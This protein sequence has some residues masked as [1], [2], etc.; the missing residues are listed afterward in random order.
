MTHAGVIRPYVVVLA[1][2]AVA[3]LVACNNPGDQQGPVTQQNQAAP[4]APAL[5]LIDA[6]APDLDT[7]YIKYVCTTIDSIGFA[8]KN[9]KPAWNHQRRP[10]T[11][12]HPVTI[13]WKVDS[14]VTID[15]IM[16]KPGPD[17]FPID[18]DPV[19]K[20]GSPGTLYKGTVQSTAGA[21]GNPPPGNP[22][23]R[24]YPYQL[25]LTCG[26]GPSPRH[27]VVDPEMII[28]KP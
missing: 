24:S 1:L 26:T 21:P 19:L 5:V 8:D 7:V 9:G 13:I 28:K 3:S 27:L 15:S 10:S 22:T 12:G 14:T 20:G 2:V 16:A 23:F 25:K 17:A 4:Q 11:P 6:I 18:V